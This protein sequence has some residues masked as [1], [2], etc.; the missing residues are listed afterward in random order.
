VAFA[1]CVLH[2]PGVAWHESVNG[3]VFQSNVNDARQRDDVL[4]PGG[5]MP[6]DEVA[7]FPLAEE[8]V[9]GRYR[10]G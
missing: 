7:G 9:L 10:R 3:A 8:D 4:P 5:G 6:I 1:G 2:Q